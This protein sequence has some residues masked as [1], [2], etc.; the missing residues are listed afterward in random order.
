MAR[1]DVSDWEVCW[2]CLRATFSFEER[3]IVGIL[4][5]STGES[6]KVV[7]RAI[8]RAASH[9]LVDS[10]GSLCFSYLTED[11][12][13]LLEFQLR[14]EGNDETRNDTRSEKADR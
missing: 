13:A 4:V 6:P 3:G 1:K 12:A 8:E 11:G 2:A 9:G 7:E 14:E 5:S 10:E